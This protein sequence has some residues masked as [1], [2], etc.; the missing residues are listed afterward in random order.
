VLTGGWG[1]DTFSC[2]NIISSSLSYLGAG[3]ATITDFSRGGG[4]IIRLNDYGANNDN[5]YSLGTGNWGGT[6]AQD[7]A[8]YYQGDLIA[9]VLDRAIDLNVDI[10]YR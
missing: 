2:V 3:F 8:I 10:E 4:D 5:Y 1:A 9:R 7:T 6:A